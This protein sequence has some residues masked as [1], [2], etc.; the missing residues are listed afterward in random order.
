MTGVGLLGVCA[1]AALAAPA[2]AATTADV[3]RAFV[4]AETV[5]P[6][7][8]TPKHEVR[9][10]PPDRLAEATFRGCSTWVAQG[11]CLVT[12][13][14]TFFADAS[15]A[16]LCSATVHEFGHL[17]GWYVAGGPWDGQHSADPESNMA[18]AHHPACGLSDWRRTMLTRRAARGRVAARRFR[19][20]RRARVA[21][22][23]AS[24]RARQRNVTK[25][26]KGT[27]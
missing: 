26:A 1:F 24:C 11:R 2:H 17:A 16:R 3:E 5:H 13:D 12:Y 25:R 18:G 10:L 15:F 7:P 14:T 4:I 8:A 23:A 20:A 22:R 6:L 27:E 21:R 19:R 9:P